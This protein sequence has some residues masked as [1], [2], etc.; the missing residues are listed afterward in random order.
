MNIISH[1]GYWKSDHNKN[2]LIAFED[3]F[4][5]GLGVETDIRDFNGQL[6]ISHDVP[7]VGTTF[8]TFEEFM[9]LAIKYSKVKPLTLALN[10]KSD[11]LA[12]LINDKLAT[13]D[14][15]YLK[16]FVFDMSVPDMRDYF[17]FG[18]SVFTRLSEVEPMP[19]WILSCS[20]VWIDSFESQWFDLDLV[21]EYLSQEK[22]VCIVSPEL[23]GRDKSELWDL[24]Y[25]LRNEA[26]ILLCTDFPVD[27]VHFFDG[28]N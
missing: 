7:L 2:S 27:A 25:P 14:C 15:E 3:S 6:V 8:T 24:I 28:R 16:C 11:G 10:I 18:L 26:G 22:E 4:S 1:R 21:R 5:M 20:G 19:S 17:S 9:L 12:K 13:L 23:H